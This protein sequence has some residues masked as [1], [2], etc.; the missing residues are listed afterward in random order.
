MGPAV[1]DRSA[2]PDAVRVCLVSVALTGLWFWLQEDLL[3]NLADE[4][5]LWYGS[6][7]TALGDVPLRDFQSYDPGRYYWIAAWSRLF[8]DGIPQGPCNLQTAK[9]IR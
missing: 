9:Q 5:F 4:G 8:G 7:R 3:L 1:A 2:L 6:W